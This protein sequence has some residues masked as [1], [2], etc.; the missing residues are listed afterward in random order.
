MARKAREK[1]ITGF[2][3][4]LLR[5]EKE[6]IFKLKKNRD[7][8]ENLVNN[9]FGGEVF[10]IKFKNDSVLMT[11]SESDNGLGNDMKPVLISFARAYNK[12]NAITGKVFKDR[13]KSVPLGTAPEN[14]DLEKISFVLKSNQN[15]QKKSSEP[16]VEPKKRNEMP[17]WLL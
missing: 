2:Y 3:A 14:V 4:V 15:I 12:E 7:L 13:F 1:S 8:F 9:S 6:D 16:K 17:T 10:E 11:V 5:G